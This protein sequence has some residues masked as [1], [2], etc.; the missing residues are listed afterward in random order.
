MK[1]ILTHEV[2]GLGAA[3]DVVDVRDG[4]G[5]NYLLPRKLATP[6]TKG[7]EKDIASIRKAREVREISTLEAAQSVKKQL[8]GMSV[9]V[10]AKAGSGGRLFGAVSSAQ[11]ADAV[12]AAGGPELDRR[13]IEVPGH[14]KTTGAYAASVRLHPEVSAKVAF[15]VVP[16]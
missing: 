14:I 12:K 16:A 9:A 3:G 7:A 5:R 1:L 11:I 4:Y 2:S 15:E 6:W 10:P 13:K 8:E